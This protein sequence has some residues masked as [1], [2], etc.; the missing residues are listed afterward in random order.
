MPASVLQA[1][2]QAAEHYVDMKELQL[3]AGERI[4]ELTKNEA[5]YIS[6][7]ASGAL[8]VAAAACMTRGDSREI[9]N[10]PCVE[11]NE[12]LI[13]RN[14]RN[15]YEL[16]VLGAGAKIV[17]FGF[18][19]QTSRAQLESAISSRSAAV[20]Y[21]IFRGG[22][23]IREGCLSL[24]ETVE[25]A[26]AHGLPVVV[27]AASQVPPVSSLWEFTQR[28]ADLA[29][30]SGGKGLLGP[31]S[32]GL[33]LG[34]Q[35]YVKASQAVGPPNHTSLRPLKV[36]KESIAGVVAAVEFAL[37]R[38][39]NAQRDECEKRVAYLLG[40]LADKNGRDVYRQA[41]SDSGQPWPTLVVR[42][43]GAYP[44]K[45]R[46]EA[47]RLLRNGEPAIMVR[48]HDL[49]GL[50]V[51]PITVLPDE[52]VVLSKKLEEAISTVCCGGCGRKT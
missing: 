9:S 35:E 41:T 25:I 14:H 37:T 33:I 26:H 21:F 6:N 27:D 13:H 36:Q 15:P 2:A 45:Q 8:Q 30:F 46:D 50:A 24:E 7:G 52:L 23:K 22:H 48:T 11:R 12:I 51:D 5:A 31:Q 29:V 47:I 17:D 40:N 44:A 19:N 4:A 43:T 10:L 49:D 34:R 18:V 16:A 32:S 1:M 39:E 3:K 20:F 42:F 38:D 28:G